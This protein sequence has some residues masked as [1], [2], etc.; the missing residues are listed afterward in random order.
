MGG[1]I[2]VQLS[3]A[4]VQAIQ[5]IASGSEPNIAANIE[6]TVNAVIIGIIPRG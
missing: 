1:I 4:L 2:T 3:G 5:Q 6:Q